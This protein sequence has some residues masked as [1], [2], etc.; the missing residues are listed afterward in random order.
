MISWIRK[1]VEQRQTARRRWEADARKLVSAD[2]VDAY[3]HAQRL[4]ARCRCAGE[5]DEF[6]HWSKVAA[7]V[8]RIEPL[9]EMNYA[10]VKAINDREKAR[11]KQHQYRASRY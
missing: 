8:A 11:H 4:A 5:T 10:K 6:G 3:Y 2:P 1:F 9:A 7:E